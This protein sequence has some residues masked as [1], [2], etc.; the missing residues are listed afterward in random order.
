MHRINPQ[1][2][3]TVE[4]I[5][6]YPKHELPGFKVKSTPTSFMFV[7]RTMVIA[8]FNGRMD[9][10]LDTIEKFLPRDLGR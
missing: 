1:F 7:N 6:R 4:N 2:P 8:T 9:C 10:Y 5:L 3:L